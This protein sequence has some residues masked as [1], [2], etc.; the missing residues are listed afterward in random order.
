MK[1]KILL[2]FSLLL[3][4][5]TH[6]SDGQST[7]RII[8]GPM[9]TQVELRTARIWVEVS[10]DTRNVAVRYWK[11]SSP[12]VMQTKEFPDNPGKDFKP[13]QVEIGGLDFNT[14][15]AYLIILNGIA[16]NATGRFTTKDLWQYR[17]PVP[18][19][20]FLAGSCAYTNE[21]VYD[22]VYTEMINLDKPSAPY[23]K[24]SSIFETM[25]KTPASFMLWLGDNWYTRDVD[26]SSEWGLW[27][28][29]SHDRRSPVMKNF[30]KA[31]PQY[32]IWD[33]HD[34]GPND[35]D[36]SY[37][38]KEA[39]RN[40]FMNYWGNP[41]YGENGQGIYS[42]MS[43][44]DADFFLMDSRYFR[45]SDF[46]EPAT[47]GK[48]DPDKRLWGKLQF[49]WLKT[50]LIN[51]RATFKCIATGSQVLNKASPYDCLWNYPAEF[52]D[53]MEFLTRE[54]IDGVI[55]LTGDRHHSEVIR[56][57][58]PGIYT[59]Y[60]VTC[61]PLTSSPSAVSGTEKDN[62]DRLP[63]TLVEVQNFTRFAI[64]GKAN[65]RTFQ[66]TFTGLKGEKL[67]EWTVHEKDLKWPAKK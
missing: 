56:Y 47:D 64:T 1:S 4:F 58:R 30:L 7:N 38:L 2:N 35:A 27:Y 40:V 63:G 18:D 8:A 3:I 28:R 25:A 32:A 46:M 17:K 24:D 42:K 50:A 44:A 34:Y 19:F 11:A 60:D 51:S 54:K 31:M 62:P 5:F 66:A 65:E 13:L 43:F 14:T 12:Q 39:S 61:S 15:Y 33:D 37:V 36:K 49:E 48:P 20:S 59:L 9:L 23:G 45:S 22:R 26:Y 21:P 41:A 55:F 53:L 16:S 57:Q 6:R 52:N 10:N 29:A 67:G